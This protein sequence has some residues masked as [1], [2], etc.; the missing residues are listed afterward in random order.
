MP[1]IYCSSEMGP[2][3]L[4]CVYPNLKIF[5]CQNG[6]KIK[7]IERAS[8][9]VDIIEPDGINIIDYMEIT[10]NFYKVAEYT[11]EIFDKLQKASVCLQSKRIL[12]QIMAEEGLL[13]LKNPGYT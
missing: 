1:I 8:N 3:E 9:F 12:K 7:F 2:V 13:D 4:K 10:D 6:E 5:K 11:K